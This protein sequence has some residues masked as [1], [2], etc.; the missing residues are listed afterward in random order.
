[1]RVGY[2]AV[3]LDII[4]HLW[5]IKQPYNVPVASQLAAEVS[6]SDRARL[7]D[8]VAKII[9]ERDKFYTKLQQIDW[10]QPYPTHTNFILCRVTGRQAIDLKQQLA[11]QG[12]LIRYYNSPVLSDCVRFSIGTPAQMSK[13]ISVL[14]QL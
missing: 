13:V 2:G 10:L 4:T 5:K 14:E 3:P 8:N 1:M 12:I 11:E 6:L 7:L 9:A